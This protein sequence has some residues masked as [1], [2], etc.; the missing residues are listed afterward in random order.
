MKSVVTGKIAISI[1][2]LCISF[3]LLAHREGFHATKVSAQIAGGYTTTGAWP[4]YVQVIIKNKGRI[5]QMCGGVLI[6]KDK[7]L[8]AAHCRLNAY[9]MEGVCIVGA[10]NGKTK[11]DTI[12]ISGASYHPRYSE[13]NLR[14]ANYKMSGTATPDMKKTN[15]GKNVDMYGVCDLAI[16][17]LSR[18]AR[19]NIIPITLAKGRNEI[20]PLILLGRGITDRKDV[21][22][23]KLFP[24]SPELLQAIVIDGKA[25]QR[26]KFIKDWI[27][28][29]AS[30][31]H[32]DHGDSGGPVVVEVA[33]RKYHLIGIT[34]AGRDSTITYS[35][36]TPQH[37][38]WILK[39]APDA[40]VA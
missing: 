23:M 5:I 32:I 8:T 1:A 34:A 38:D 7:V 39:R 10:D 27:E 11:Y 6:S 21:A 14:Y 12:D 4:W 19:S 33:P 28:F 13:N 35:T 18:P 26:S 9:D 15:E 22:I 30:T 24:K 17:T 16:I 37:L 2:A 3:S 40:K 29:P 31:H 36:H 20:N 25:P